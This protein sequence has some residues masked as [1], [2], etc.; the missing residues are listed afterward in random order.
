MTE[1]LSRRVG[2]GAER[3]EQSEPEG[4][5]KASVEGREFVD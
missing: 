3:R 1:G 5:R 4:A 2:K